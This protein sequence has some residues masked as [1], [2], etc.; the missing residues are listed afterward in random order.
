MPAIATPMST[1]V[2]QPVQRRGFSLDDTLRLPLNDVRNNDA[3]PLRC[4]MPYTPGKHERAASGLAISEA[5]G[6]M[7]ARRDAAEDAGNRRELN[8]LNRAMAWVGPG[9]AAPPKP[10]VQAYLTAFG[11]MRGGL[12]FLQR[13]AP[14]NEAV[15]RCLALMD[16]AI[17]NVCVKIGRCDS[18]PDGYGHGGAS[19]KLSDEI[20]KASRVM[21]QCAHEVGRDDVMWGIAKAMLP[22][23]MI[24]SIAERTPDALS[25]ILRGDAPP[26]DVMEARVYLSLKNVL[27]AAL[28]SG[29]PVALANAI[30]HLLK[31]PEYVETEVRGRNGDQPKVPEQA[32]TPFNPGPGAQPFPTSGAPWAYANTHAPVTVN[33]DLSEFMR[34]QQAPQLTDIRNLVNDLLDR[35]YAMGVSHAENTQLRAENTALR[36][37]NAD[38]M[39]MLRKDNQRL[40]LFAKGPDLVRVPG[41]ASED[42][43][44]ST[45]LKQD[46]PPPSDDRNPRSALDP[47]S[48]RAPRVP[49]VNR[50]QN[51]L[52]RQENLN[53]QDNEQRS[54][55]QL[56]R[57]DNGAG[58]PRNP[59]QDNDADSRNRL[60][61]TLQLDQRQR[62]EQNR[63]LQRDDGSNRSGGL[64]GDGSGT[65]YAEFKG[66]LQ[67]AEYEERIEPRDKF[68]P[69]TER[70]KDPNVVKAS[71]VAKYVKER[72]ANAGTPFVPSMKGPLLPPVHSSPGRVRELIQELGAARFVPSKIAEEEGTVGLKKSAPATLP[73]KSP[74]QEG[75]EAFFQKRDL[76]LL[77]LAQSRPSV[78]TQ[79]ASAVLGGRTTFRS[80]L[81]TLPSSPIAARGALNRSASLAS[82]ASNESD[83]SET[84][85]ELGKRIFSASRQSRATLPPRAGHGPLNAPT[86]GLTPLALLARS[87]PSAPIVETAVRTHAASPASP[88]SANGQRLDVL[89]QTIV[90]DART[91][92]GEKERS[93]SFSVPR[94]PQESIDPYAVYEFLRDGE[95]LQ[96]DATPG[97]QYKSFNEE[98]DALSSSSTSSA[99]SVA[100]DEH[101]EHVDFGDIEPERDN[102]VVQRSYSA[103]SMDSGRDSPPVLSADESGESKTP[104]RV[105][106]RAAVNPK[107]N[108][109][110]DQ[111]VQLI[112][113]LSERLKRVKETEE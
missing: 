111:H 44:D 42:E 12:A 24:E 109:L 31:A 106:D 108:D 83:A 54:D 57:G 66:F 23:S 67:A 13:E 92:R 41:G 76:A 38:L 6:V 98:W 56:N 7:K 81:D 100:G 9:S 21:L 89:R 62:D 93:V 96:S 34:N 1:Q 52:N 35:G 19:D 65:H 105:A 36:K 80:F 79:P 60:G 77:E 102:M 85:S 72:S 46:T 14:H 63:Y 86:A 59:K 84:G 101:E 18:P 78:Q 90:D 110:A 75:M 50:R 33:N 68:E 113:E 49:D 99:S 26:K 69:P 27:D 17:G 73:A 47:D 32:R 53:R 91:P 11:G 82:I 104:L 58:G 5:C 88:G 71:H 103:V 97:Q 16:N 61:G 20:A 70:R 55:Q 112:K 25:K 10:K 94:D 43:V 107:G 39:E 45:L 74:L 4:Q 87:I 3:T 30:L 64:G 8:A 29:E 48:P 15:N 2:T 28:D 51:Q 22:Q 40:S 95:P 37:Q